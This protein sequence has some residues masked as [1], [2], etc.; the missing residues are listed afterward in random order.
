MAAIRSGCRVMVSPKVSAIASRVMSSLVGP[1]PPVQMMTSD[2]SMHL[3]SI[4]TISPISSPIMVTVCRSTPS[5][6]NRA[7]MWAELVSRVS[8]MRS[9]VPNDR[10]SARM[11]DSPLVQVVNALS[12]GER[13]V[14]AKGED[15]AGKALRQTGAARRRYCAAGVAS[16]STSA[17]VGGS[18]TRR[19]SVSNH[20][21]S[22]VR[23]NG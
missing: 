18:S 2:R 1:S 19:S 16:A 8:P 10:I 15:W 13:Q 6:G 14:H 17:M 23:R 22:T 12:I 3:R 7:A 9:S 11:R 4:S 21:A 5:A 20:G